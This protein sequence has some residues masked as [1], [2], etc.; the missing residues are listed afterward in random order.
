LPSKAQRVLRRLLH[1]S[2]AG[3]WTGRGRQSPHEEKRPVK[4]AGLY[5]FHA[6]EHG[7]PTRGCH[8]AV[9]I[10]VDVS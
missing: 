1:L 8:R 4:I 2:A 5:G 10:A 9:A 6:T 7:C 3:Y